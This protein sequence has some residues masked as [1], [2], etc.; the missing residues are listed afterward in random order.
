MAVER[1]NPY[2]GPRSFKSGDKLY[3]RDWESEELRDLLIAKRIVLLHSPS[4]AGKTSLIHAVLLPALENEGFYLHPPIRVGMDPPSEV[5]EAGC[6]YNR[7][8]LSALISLGGIHHNPDNLLD[9]C[10]IDLPTYLAQ[11]SED[12]TAPSGGDRPPDEL[13]VFDQFEEILTVDPLDRA[14]REEFF[15]QL[16]EA[17]RG[18]QH[19]VLFAMREDYVG[20]LEPYLHHVPTRLTTHVR[21]E[22]LG[23]QAALSAIKKPAQ[24]HGVTYAEGVAEELLDDLLELPQGKADFVEPVQLQV[25]CHALWD[26]WQEHAPP[27]SQTI[28]AEHAAAFGDVDQAL[29]Q[30]YDACIRQT[31]QETGISERALRRW[32]S[33]QMIT[34]AGTRGIVYKGQSETAGIPNAA[35]HVLDRLHIIRVEPRAGA[36]WVEIAHDGFITPIQESNQAWAQAYRERQIRRRARLALLLAIPVALVIIALLAR[37]WLDARDNERRAEER[38][39]SELATQAFFAQATA[40]AQAAEV[41][42]EKLNTTLANAEAALNAGDTSLAIAL[43]LEAHRLA[44]QD[45]QL[46]AQTSS[47]MLG[48]LAQAAYAPGIRDRWKLAPASEYGPA[49]AISQDRAAFA[50][51]PA[52][53]SDP[54]DEVPTVILWNLATGTEIRRLDV[55]AG[56]DGPIERLAFSPGGERLLVLTATSLSLWD[57][58]SGSILQSYQS[59]DVTLTAVAFSADGRVALVGGGPGMIQQEARAWIELW[60]LT[61]WQPIRSFDL[62]GETTISGLTFSADGQA[63]YATTS[64]PGLYR[65]DIKTGHPAGEALAEPGFTLQTLAASPDGQT[66]LTGSAEGVV[67]LWDV[68][69]GQSTPLGEQT[70]PVSSIAVSHD[71]QRA[72]MAWTDGS[73]E[74]WHLGRRSRVAHFAPLGEPLVTVAFSQD[75][76]QAI[77]AAGDGSLLVWDLQPGNLV[78][79]LDGHGA[80][81]TALVASPD[82]QR[83]LSGGCRLRSTDNACL[84]SEIIQLDL[85]AGEIVN[86]VGVSTTPVTALALS[87]DGAWGVAGSGDGTLSPLQWGFPSTQP[88]PEFP[89]PL[90]GAAITA[91]GGRIILAGCADA[92]AA[93]ADCARSEI[94]V[95]DPASERELDRV[96][97]PDES[98]TALAWSPDG[99]WGLLGTAFGRLVWLR[100]DADGKLI[101]E[102]LP[103][104][105]SESS[106][107]EIALQPGTD[108]R[109]AVIARCAL[110][111]CAQS[112]VALIDL[113]TSTQ[114]PIDFGP[115]VVTG[116]VLSQN[117]QLALG[118]RSGTVI[119]WDMTANAE[120]YRFQAHTGAVSGLAFYAGGVRLVTAG[121]PTIKQWRADTFDDMAAWTANNRYAELTCAE[122]LASGLACQPP[123]PLGA[124]ETGSVQVGSLQPG[125]SRA[126]TFTNVP[127]TR[128]T[129]EL[130]SDDALQGVVLLVVDSMGRVVEPD[131]ATTDQNAQNATYTL[132][133]EGPYTV[134]LFAGSGSIDYRLAVA[135][136]SLAVPPPA[137]RAATAT[138]SVSPSPE[139]TATPEL[140]PMLSYGETVQDTVPSDGADLWAFEGTAGDQVS[141]AM[142]RAATDLDSYLILIGPDNS[143]LAYDDNS[144]DGPDALIGGFMLPETGLYLIQAYGFGE[145]GAYTLTLLNLGQVTPTPSPSP[146]PLPE[147]RPIAPG[148]PVQSTLAANSTET[149]SFEGQAGQPVTITLRDQN[150]LLVPSL[151][152]LSAD[153]L[154]Y[155]QQSATEQDPVVTLG[156]IVLPE[157]GVYIIAV[158]EYQ[159]ASGDYTLTLTN[160]ALTTPTPTVTPSATPAPPTPTPSPSPVA[161]REVTAGQYRGDLPVG[162]R[163]VWTYYGC[164]DERISVRVEADSPANT[165]PVPP[166][167]TLD[168]TISVRAPDGQFIAQADD[169]VVAVLTDA[170]I[171]NLRLPATGTYEIEVRG[172]DFQTGG[173]YTLTI[174]TSGQTCAPE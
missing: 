8:V 74:Y 23:R 142:R 85:V 119:V 163:D 168:A 13:L 148:D 25:V 115:G 63:V 128:L 40:T 146:T 120:L 87:Q 174:E 72:L 30:F 41:R 108:A 140:L 157:T 130:T 29:S 121:G 135:E 59:F 125:E 52:P 89:G 143:E 110:D 88:R 114:R 31:A 27:D 158:R 84:Q 118:L 164:L 93:L 42:A 153:G 145:D 79:A 139:V 107:L 33:E 147:A 46:A 70:L 133:Q 20:G 3:G 19:W 62:P 4:G 96:A 47:R 167:G 155:A 60:D 131:D 58:A 151:A 95:R 149:W 69:T 100:L 28:T 18:S 99:D 45:P 38:A 36:D 171:E 48:L 91:D 166:P 56:V 17:L 169:I 144:G 141:I 80:G 64:G 162:G 156:N 152:L 44:Q 127:G 57:S 5:I 86:R 124:F 65:W 160:L 53:A 134:A 54:P 15:R 104:K 101:Q 136:R 92:V 71:G 150:T 113:A 34:P 116:L 129:F 32:F 165:T 12:V 105:G 126:W 123:E 22:R 132:P 16:G 35:V 67:F 159:G 90:T 43:V 109:R 14:G 173:A 154:L 11:L 49:L 39:E 111:G 76:R 97:L 10:D 94:V 112:E 61:T 82:R 78:R 24:A 81:A 9:L 7:Y 75:D 98:V 83:A 122:R 26:Y 1:S 51:N 106:V 102:P 66:V 172:F 21:L 55:T 170:A 68:A 73:L 77:G 161:Q 103:A 37:L 117:G 138:P 137:T 6:A 50:I 2:V